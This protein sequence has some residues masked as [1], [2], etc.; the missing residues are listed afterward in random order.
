LIDEE[1]AVQLFQ[2]LKELPYEQRETFVLHIQGDMK[3][4]EIANL[5]NVSIK[6][7]QSRYRYGVEK[8]QKLLVRD[9]IHEVRK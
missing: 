8:L 7:V 9:N 6:T 2:A 5:Q 3:F 4:R 1:K